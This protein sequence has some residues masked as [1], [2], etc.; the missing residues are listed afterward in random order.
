MVLPKLITNNPIMKKFTLLL[1]FLC[2]ISCSEDEEVIVD[3]VFADLE[4]GAIL[5][6]V[7]IES[8]E[9]NIND[10]SSA[11]RIVIEEND[12]EDGGLLDKVDIQMR[13]ID[14]DNGVPSVISSETYVK[15]IDFQDFS[16][17]NSTLPR[18]GVE[19][20]FGEAMT[21]MN[22]SADQVSCGDQFLIRLE[23]LLTDGR[24]FN[25]EDAN[26]YIIAMES[27]NNSPFCYTIN[28][29]EP[30]DDDLFIGNYF[31]ESILDGPLGPSFG[32][33]GILEIRRGHSSTTRTFLTRHVS[34]AFYR[35]A[36][37]YEF[38]ISCDESIFSKFQFTTFSNACSGASGNPESPVLLGPSEVNAV[39]NRDDDSVFEVWLTEGF[40]GYNGNCGYTNAPS[41]IRFTRQ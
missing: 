7:F 16:R 40:D 15:S 36:Y 12:E 41:R 2:L 35:Q 28:V 6:T 37:N 18:A 22:I 26:S 23:L 19:M 34:S 17:A 5:R 30:L 25:L 31:Y 27:F 4:I 9:F 21:A 3:Q 29:V 32:E 11:I 8:G 24:T 38:T 13:F 14:R 33:S 20:T 10:P 39:I 1:A